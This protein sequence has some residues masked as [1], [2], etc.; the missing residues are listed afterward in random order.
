MKFSALLLIVLISFTSCNSL[1][2][3]LKCIFENPKVKKSVINLLKG[4]NAGEQP[5]ILISKV[6]IAFTEIKKAYGVC[7]VDEPTLK[8]GC[9]FEEQFKNCQLKKIDPHF[10]TRKLKYESMNNYDN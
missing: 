4:I 10:S 2:D 6:Y 5:V 3:K 9:R 1:V 7:W 8:G